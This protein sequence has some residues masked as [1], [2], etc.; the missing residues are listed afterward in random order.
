MNKPCKCGGMNEECQ[1]C[2]GKGFVEEKQIEIIKTDIDIN[3]IKKEE[4][5]LK[6]YLHNI[7]EKM[8]LSNKKS[9]ARR[10]KKPSV[11]TEKEKKEE[12]QLKY[13]GPN[14]PNRNRLGDT[15]KLARKKS[16]QKAKR[17]HNNSVESEFLLFWENN[18]KRKTSESQEFQECLSIFLKVTKDKREKF[19]YAL[20]KNNPFKYADIVIIAQKIFDKLTG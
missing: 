13:I 9:I 18:I 1:F 5:D 17:K 15:R 12:D 6:S 4:S 3:R 16:T 11:K 7:S 14:N 20:L 2:G 19:K 10:N 8:Y